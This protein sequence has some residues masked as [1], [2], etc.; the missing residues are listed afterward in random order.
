MPFSRTQGHIGQLNRPLRIPGKLLK[1]SPD[2]RIGQ[3][4][5]LRPRRLN[6]IFRPLIEQAVVEPDP[7]KREQ[8]YFEI[9]KLRHEHV[10]E[11]VLSQAGESLYEQRWVKGFFFNPAATYQ[12]FFYGYE[13]AGGE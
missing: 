4:F 3:P 12:S 10:P 9:G 5:K 1:R 6:D 7:A 2:V 8:I 13:L 11:V